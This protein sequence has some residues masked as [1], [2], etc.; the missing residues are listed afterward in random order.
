MK[1]WKVKSVIY[2]CNLSNFNQAIFP[3]NIKTMFSVESVHT[4]GGEGH[5]HA[6]CQI[7]LLLILKDKSLEDSNPISFCIPVFQATQDST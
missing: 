6:L 3:V 5:K 4:V 2:F 7:A 1:L